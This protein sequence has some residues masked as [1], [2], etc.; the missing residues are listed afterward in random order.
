MTTE[1]D[2]L[3]ATPFHDA[4][5][6]LRARML[7]RLADTELFVLLA[8]DPADDRAELR[9]F[10]L[11]GGSVAMAADDAAELASFLGG[12]V[13]HLTMPGRALAAMLA[14]ERQGLLVNPGRASEMLLDA[15]ALAWLGQALAVAPEA[16][17][18]A[19]RLTAPRPDA[20][21]ALAEPLAQRLADMAGRIAGA[22]LVGADWPDGR[23]GH[24]L[25]IAGAGE[26]DRP[27]LAKALAELLAFLPELPGGVDVTFAALALPPGALTITPEP[28]EPAAA[29]AP[30]QRSDA[31]PRL[32]W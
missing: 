4:D 9:H 7:S 24:I 18:G 12:P 2:R 1:L 17:D 16:T 3:A 31:P 6:A 5:P 10:D 23:Q 8:G 30:A 26:A 22:A 25:A 14:A 20:V 29:P 27:A 19:A 11:P 28:V 13:P 32:R 15:A 21:A